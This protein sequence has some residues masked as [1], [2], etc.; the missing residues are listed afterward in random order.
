MR[1]TSWT[2]LKPATPLFLIQFKMKYFEIF[3]VLPLICGTAYARNAQNFD[4]FVQQQGDSAPQYL[5]HHNNPDDYASYQDFLNSDIQQPPL[6]K[7][8]QNLRQDQPQKRRQ[9]QHDLSDKFDVYQPQTVSGQDESSYFLDQSADTE[10]IS[11]HDTI[12]D[13]ADKDARY[14]DSRYEYHM[15]GTL[16][17]AAR[18]VGG[19][20]M[21]SVKGVTDFIRDPVGGLKGAYEAVRHPVDSAEGAWYAIKQGTRKNG[22]TYSMA[23]AATTGVMLA[24]P[25]KLLRNPLSTVGRVATSGMTNTG[26]AAAFISAA[27]G[28]EQ[29]STHIGNLQTLRDINHNRMDMLQSREQRLDEDLR[30]ARKRKYDEAFDPYTQSMDGS[31]VHDEVSSADQTFGSADLSFE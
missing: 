31:G 18:G 16:D 2:M 24:A 12:Y 4:V 26:R 11:I 27:E 7:Q 21:R 19:T 10:Q 29:M 5:G 17:N 1:A 30:P 6:K 14:E 28:A 3:L 13:I 15:R 22:L 23:T 9:K 20:V 8:R 25:I